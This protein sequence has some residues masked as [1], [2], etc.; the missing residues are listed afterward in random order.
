MDSQLTTKSVFISE[1]ITEIPADFPRPVQLGAV[2]GAQP[3]I[4]VIA[5][6]GRFLAPE[7]KQS[8]LKQRFDICEDLVHQL[9]VKS[10]ESKAGK[11]A[12]LSEAEI[13]LQYRMRLIA[14]KWTS[15]EEAHWIIDKVASKIGWHLSSG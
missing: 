8:E 13:L 2:S 12:H 10:L 3:K 5:K 4:L 6:H 11:R 1:K 7:T 14:T 9:A 15:V